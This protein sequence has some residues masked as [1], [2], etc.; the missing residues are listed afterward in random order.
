M[1][2]LFVNN[3]Q[4]FNNIIQNDQYVAVMFSAGFCNPCR[5]IFPFICEQAEK[6]T[7]I[8][9]I[10]VDIQEGCDISDIYNIQSIPHF[11]FFKNNS[12][13]VSFSGANKQFIKDSIEKIKC[14]EPLLDN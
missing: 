3:L 8:K 1:S 10:K 2:V 5:D 12:E 11:K 9:F 7:D 13:L 14:D 4:E 6:N